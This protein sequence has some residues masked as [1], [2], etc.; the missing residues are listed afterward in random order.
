[1]EILNTIEVASVL[2]CHP[3]TVRELVHR[4]KL[5]RLQGTGT[6]IFLFDAKEVSIFP[7]VKR[8]R[9]RKIIGLRPS[10]LDE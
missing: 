1:M 5:Q 9:P 3:Q 7:K 4:G 10:D 2:N 8:G 6:G